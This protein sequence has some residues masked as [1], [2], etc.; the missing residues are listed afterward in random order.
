MSNFKDFD[1]D[2]KNVAADGTSPASVTSTPCKVSKWTITQSLE[3]KCKSIEQPTTGM[4]SAC[5]K[6]KNA[7]DEP[8]CI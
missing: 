8:Q 1:L 6:K 7:A 2:L 4:T 3:N 5:C